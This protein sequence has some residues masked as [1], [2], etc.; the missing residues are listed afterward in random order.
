MLFTYISVQLIIP[1]TSNLNKGLL[2]AIPTLPLEVIINKLLL[3]LLIIIG[4]AELQEVIMRLE[5][6]R[7]LFILKLGTLYKYLKSIIL[8]TFELLLI[9][10]F[11][12]LLLKP[13]LILSNVDVLPMETLF[14]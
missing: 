4:F 9:K 10:K 13:K 14:E 12:L 8:E 1:F 7:L 2:L 3:L 5:M 6:L 11:N